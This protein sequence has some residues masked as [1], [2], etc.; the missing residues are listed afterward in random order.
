L[1]LK[2]SLLGK[3]GPLSGHYR[4]LAGSLCITSSSTINH[5]AD[6]LLDRREI[7]VPVKGSRCSSD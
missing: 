1:K 2:I 5:R 7:S 6:S 3:E 4:L